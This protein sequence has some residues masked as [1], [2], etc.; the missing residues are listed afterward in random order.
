MRLSK[1]QSSRKMSCSLDQI[2][3]TK[4]K[5]LK[6]SW[7]LSDTDIDNA[8]AFAASHGTIE[9]LHI[10]KWLIDSGASSHMTN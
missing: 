9:S 6:N 5:L 1:L 4:P 7:N 10:R 8:G 3:P 2:H